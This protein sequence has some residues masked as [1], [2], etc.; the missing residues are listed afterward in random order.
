MFTIWEKS[1]YIS[2][3]QIWKIKTNSL[4][5]RKLIPCVYKIQQIRNMHNSGNFSSFKSISFFYC[6]T[7]ICINKQRANLEYRLDAE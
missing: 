2:A 3:N 1:N 4:I 6:E 7:H 5:H